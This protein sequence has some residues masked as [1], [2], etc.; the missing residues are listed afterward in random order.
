MKEGHKQY[1]QSIIDA[2]QS[3]VRQLFSDYGITV[4][5]TPDAIKNAYDVFGKPFIGDLVNAIVPR[6]ESAEGDNLQANAAQADQKKS[7]WENISGVLN[8][9]AAVL[10]GW[11]TAFGKGGATT[12]QT[13]IIIQQPEAKKNNTWLFLGIGLLVVILLVVVLIVKHK[14]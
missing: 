12:T 11:G 9:T 1:L 4:E 10:T 3:G 8:G 13:P 14:K 5:P 2:R 6:Y 7:L